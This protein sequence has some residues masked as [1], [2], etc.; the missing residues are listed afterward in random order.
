MLDVGCWRSL[1]NRGLRERDPSLLADLLFVRSCVFQLLEI[2]GVIDLE[3]ED[4]ALAERFAID[5]AW[6]CFE[7]FVYLDHFAFYRR[8]DVAGGFDGFDHRDRLPCV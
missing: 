8:I 5:Q 4:P 7:R 2:F 3:N 1:L 6:I